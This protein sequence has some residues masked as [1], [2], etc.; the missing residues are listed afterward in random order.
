[1]G[2]AFPALKENE[3]FAGELKKPEYDFT[4]PVNISDR[5]AIDFV[6]RD[7]E[8]ETVVRFI[9]RKYNQ[10]TT[11]SYYISTIIEHKKGYGLTL[12]GGFPEWTVDAIATTKAIE[13]CEYYKNNNIEVTS[14]YVEGQ[15]IEEPETHTLTNGTQSFEMGFSN[16]D[17]GVLKERYAEAKEEIKLNFV[18]E[19]L[20]AAGI[21]VVTNKGEFD[22]IL[23]NQTILQKMTY[24]NKVQELFISKNNENL[25]AEIDTLSIKDVNLWN[26]YIN[27][28][29]NTPFIFNQFFKESEV[30]NYPVNIY[31]QKLA[32]AL[33]MKKEKFGERVTHGHKGEFSDKE[34]KEVFKNISNPRYIF[35]SRKNKDNPDHYYLIGVYDTFDKLGNPM[36]LT[37]HYE[38]NRKQVEANWVTS[39]F[40]RDLNTLVDY[41]TRSGFLVYK[42]DLELEKASEEVVALY[43]RVSN[44]Q[45]P[46][47]EMV[48]QKSD[49]VNDEG[50]FFYKQNE[51]IYGFAYEGKIYLNPEIMNSEVAVHEYTHLW[52][53]YIQRTN[54]E[55]WEKGKDIFRSIKSKNLAVTAQIY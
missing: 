18:L 30:G 53:K 17:V 44:L 16:K 55:L 49:Y 13:I 21:E 23:T 20:A 43:M 47:E 51:N 38:K 34:V 25:N 5:F 33:F 15:N 48:K 12:D 1:M 7:N 27:I 28:S 9:D 19:K 36:T 2:Y 45:K 31:K 4:Q 6:K 10:I 14:N 35:N 26:K 52:D 22:R 24:E 11:G 54:P 29:K 39:V 41:W 8:K 32:R 50:L 37:L 3:L 40:G 46:Y 42:N